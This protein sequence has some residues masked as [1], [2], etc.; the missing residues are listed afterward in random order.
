MSEIAYQ[1]NCAFGLESVVK[2]ELSDLGYEAKGDSLG[3]VVFSADLAAI[4][5][6]QLWL[7]AGD[8]LK[9]VVGKFPAPDFDTLFDG[10]QQLPWENWIPSTGAFPVTARSH[11]SQLTSVPAL[12]RSVKK[13]IVLRLMKAHRAATLEETKG[14]YAVEVELLND[15]ATLTLDATGPSLHKRGYRRLIGEAPL[16]ETMAAALVLLSGW[17]WERPLLDPFCGTG[18]ICLEAAL[19]GRNMAPGER[20]TFNAEVWPVT[21][22]SIWRNAREEA[23]DLAKRNRPLQI[24]G[25]DADPSA[26]KLAGHHR[27]A[28]GFSKGIT[29]VERD[30]SEIEP[31]GEYGSL[32]TNPPYGE[33]LGERDDAADLYREFPRVLRRFTTWSHHIIAPTEGFEAMMGQ[34]ASRRRKLYNGRLECTYFQ[35]FGPRPPRAVVEE[36]LRIKQT[37]ELAIAIPQQAEVFVPASEE[38]IAVVPKGDAASPPGNA[39]VPPSETVF[40]PNEF[41][42]SENKVET[43]FVK[44]NADNSA[45]RAASTKKAEPRLPLAPAFGGL[46][47]KAKQQA[48]LFNSRLT[49]N[50]RHLRRWPTRQD[51]HCYRL[52]DR[53]IPEIPLCV[54]RYEDYLHIA[55]YDRP[56]DRTPAQHADWLDLMVETAA[57]AIEIPLENVYLKRRERKRG[58]EQYDKLSDEAKTVVVREGGLKFQVNLTDYLDVG[59][60]LDHRQTRRKVREVAKGKRFLNLFCYTGSFTVY[61]ADGGAVNTVSVD[62]NANYLDWARRNLALNG[63]WN[64]KHQLVCADVRGYLAELPESVRF[65]LIVCDPPTFSNSKRLPDYF[66]VQRD[67]ADLLLVLGSHLSEQGEIYFSTN[68]RRFKLEE[69]P[70]L[71]A[72]EITTHTIPPDFR[73]ERIHRCW[74]I[75]HE[76]REREEEEEEEAEV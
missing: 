32:I 26:I 3:R 74:R 39:I 67:H 58:D 61:A 10:V 23:N 76:P 38:C 59:L 51:I 13:A 48:Q 14:E 63:L 6:C 69:L 16:K 37:E 12:Q 47:E 1:V 60:F 5:R 30:F 46:G 54:D 25:S 75:I 36:P 34:T 50:A 8:R 40:P 64:A 73:N 9:I 27:S 43:D 68:Y 56:H 15:Q 21:P 72:R 22:E 18:T 53:D 35:F 44:A 65:D 33:R 7:R 17:R 55:E 28:L 31:F 29:F 45:V 19:I 71:A 11:K 49:K 52:Y 57:K 2:R 24:V 4:A 66:D 42:V 20:R 41:A 62:S 70:G